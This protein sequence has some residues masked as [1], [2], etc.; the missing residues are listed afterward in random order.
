MTPVDFFRALLRLVHVLAAVAWIGGS[1]F[2]LMVLIPSLAL[3]GAR[4]RTKDVR[5][6]ITVR[7][8]ELTSTCLWAVV[9]TGVMITVDRLSGGTSFTYGAT[10]AVKIALVGL[11]YLVYLDLGARIAA[12]G[13]WA[14]LIRLNRPETLLGLGVLVFLVTIVLRMI[15]EADLRVLVLG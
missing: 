2:Y 11:M 1:A 8:R 3:P 7:F 14:F 6:S 4:E 15:Y 13:R 12:T 5:D 9:L 10:L